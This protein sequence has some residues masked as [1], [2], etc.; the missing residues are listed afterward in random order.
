MTMTNTLEDSFPCIIFDSS[1]S[2]VADDSV[3]TFCT[4]FMGDSNKS[5][6]WGLESTSHPVHVAAE[7]HQRWQVPRMPR[8]RQSVLTTDNLMTA[9][10]RRSTKSTFSLES[11]AS[12]VRRVETT[13]Q[14]FIHLGL[15]QPKSE[16]LERF[17]E[18][19]P[20]TSLELPAKPIRQQSIVSLSSQVLL[21]S[22]DQEE[23][24][25]GEQKE[26][27]DSD[28]IASVIDSLLQ[29]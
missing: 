23:D 13:A 1:N 16:S 29:E 12:E 18:P 14:Q 9:P 28:H 26:Q 24:D 4:S 19:K 3:I 5:L 22:V 6:G 10:K 7:S 21:E 20:R 25:D 17:E 27:E 11:C 2:D 8:R 15:Q